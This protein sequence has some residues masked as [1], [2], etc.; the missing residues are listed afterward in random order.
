VRD[1]FLKQFPALTPN[2][3]R[4]TSMG[5]SG[6]DVQLSEAARSLIPFDTE[7]KSRASIAVYPY[8]QQAAENTSEGRKPLLVIKQ[9]H[10]EPLAVLRLEDLLEILK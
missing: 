2:D 5:A 9:N 1:A 3:V 10:S 6:L 7:C 4:S 8:F